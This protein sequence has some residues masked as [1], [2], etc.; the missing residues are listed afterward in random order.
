MTEQLGFV[1]WVLGAAHWIA[2]SA[3]YLAALIAV[4]ALV[5]AGKTRQRTVLVR[6][7]LAHRT[8]VEVIPTSTFDPSEGEIGRWAHQ[9]GRVPA[10]AGGVPARGAAARLRYSVE[11]GKMRCYLEGPEQAA[12]ILA[13]PGFAEVEV[14]SDRTH[15]EI[16]PI[17]FHRPVHPRESA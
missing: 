11:A 17:R 16:R 3:P 8:V 5:W 7:A 4:G 15:Q 12:A 14:R 13:M 6:E 1:Q 10:A 2:W 9:L